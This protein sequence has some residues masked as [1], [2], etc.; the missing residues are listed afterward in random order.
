L[1][2]TAVRGS[3]IIIVSAPLAKRK[4]HL[5]SLKA[6]AHRL[7]SLKQRL[8]RWAVAK[9]ALHETPSG[10]AELAEAGRGRQRAA[11]SGAVEK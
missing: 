6:G 2:W 9:R 7:R 11:L 8:E 10:A 5:E 3:P 4:C 1:W